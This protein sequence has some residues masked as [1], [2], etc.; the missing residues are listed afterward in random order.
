[1]EVVDPAHLSL[2]DR[3]A[4][5]TMAHIRPGGPQQLS[6]VEAPTAPTRPRPRGPPPPP[7]AH[8]PRARSGG[9]PKLPER[10]PPKYT[11]SPSPAPSSHSSND[12]RPV[13][14]APPLP[15]RTKTLPSSGPPP[16]PPPLPKRSPS[17]PVVPHGATGTP[18]ETKYSLPPLGVIPPKISD[19][20][21]GTK[22]SSS[23]DPQTRPPIP[24][25]PSRPAGPVLPKPAPPE[26]PGRATAHNLRPTPP[27][28]PAPYKQRNIL[29]LG[30]GGKNGKLPSPPRSPEPSTQSPPPIPSSTK[31]KP[32]GPPPLPGARPTISHSYSA[33]PP[34]GVCL[35]CR[36]FSQPDAH[37]ARFPRHAYN[38]VQRLALDLTAPFESATDKARVIFTWLHHNVVYDVQNFFNNSVKPSTPASTLKTGLAVCEGFAGLFAA[39]AVFA[40]LEAI[41][42]GGH[43]K[44]YGWT[45]T[46]KSFVPPF[47][48]NHA[49]N[50]C[51][52]DGGEWHLIDPCWGAGH[53][54]ERST[55]SQI[56]DPSHFTGTN[57][58]FGRRHYPSNSEYQ[59]LDR[60]ITWEQY[61][62]LQE[63]GPKTFSHM[64]DPEFN[65]GKDTAEPRQKVLSPYSRHNF[66][67]TG[68]CEHTPATTQWIL[69][70]SN[71][72]D[73]ETMVSD[74]RGGLVGSIAAGASGTKIQIRAIHMF[75]GASAKGLT[76]RKWDDRHK[77][78]WSCSYVAIC[79]WVVG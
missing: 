25:L 63:A 62:L 28:D 69:Q 16:K 18:T 66:R 9:P 49:W 30:F 26:L 76:H 3:K 5:L 56:F 2:A 42:V 23:R 48:G 78:G 52:I 58:E 44:G 17:S 74:G 67:L 33:Q 77:G 14:K 46:D 65:F 21:W 24:K 39:M 11:P 34:N 10:P 79:E 31:P 72:Q 13:L 64:T 50:A 70:L 60:P 41:V 4:A 47:K 22:Q 35:K 55:Y 6:P 40:G 1:M 37:A 43:G 73:E 54:N 7:P 20:P 57:E 71:G 59:F 75:N 68:V 8:P 53:L 15:P 51:R 45:E 12:D 38:D 29:E 27:T 19:R 61:F 36:D 32:S